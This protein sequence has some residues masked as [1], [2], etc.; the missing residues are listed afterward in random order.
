DLIS[1]KIS[2][3]AFSPGNEL[4]LLSSF[5][6]QTF[7]KYAITCSNSRN[8]IKFILLTWNIR[9]LSKSTSKPSNLK[10]QHDPGKQME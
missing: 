8:T 4:A 10:Q 2:V 9:N 3:R 5:Q 1:K 6:N 7:K